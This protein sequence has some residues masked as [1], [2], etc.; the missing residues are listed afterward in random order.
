MVG[1]WFLVSNGYALALVTADETLGDESTIIEP[2]SE[3]ENVLTIRGGAKRGD[4]LFHS[5][6]TFS[7]TELQRVEFDV[8]EGVEQ[9][10]AR[11]TGENTSAIA[12]QVVGPNNV[13]VILI[14]PG[15]VDFIA[16]ASGSED[17][18]EQ[19]DMGGSILVSTADT[20]EF[21]LNSENR[22]RFSACDPEVPP[23]S[24]TI[25]PSALLFGQA[26][27]AEIT[28]QAAPGN[29]Q[30]KEGLTVQPGKSLVLL[31]G[32][33]TV[34]ARKLTAFG[35]RIEIGAVAE[36]GKVGLTRAAQDWILDVPLNIALGNVKLAAA[37]QATIEA[38]EFGG[39]TIKLTAAAV[40]LLDAAD[41]V[42]DTKGNSD[43]GDI[44]ILASDRVT[45]K[46]TGPESA[47]FGGGIA[48]NVL[49]GGTGAG[50]NI[51]IAAP[52]VELLDGAQLQT[53][54]Q[55]TG[56]AGSIIISADDQVTISGVGIDGFASGIFS[57][58]FECDATGAG[59]SIMISTAMLDAKKGAQL[60]AGNTCG[61]GSP[62]SIVIS[63]SKHVE[64]T[65]D[66]AVFSL[67]KGSRG[68]GGLIAIT[69]PQLTMTGGS[70]LVTSARGEGNGGDIMI[71]AEEQVTFDGTTE[72][73]SVEEQ[74]S[75]AF[76]TVDKGGVGGDITIATRELTVQQGAQLS[77]SSRG[78]GEAGQI[79]I[80]AST[81]AL[82]DG[83]SRNFSSGAYS[84]A[85]GGGR[86]EE[87]RML[88]KTPSCELQN[89]AI[90]VPDLPSCKDP[91]EPNS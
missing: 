72:E 12:G 2:A 32:D 39:G 10:I 15:G 26:Q 36:S 3:I 66:S 62:G 91:S 59:G 74:P 14:S 82:F 80:L 87:K 38:D 21:E 27:P 16:S 37:A 52:L 57:D 88:I 53:A 81:R 5:F 63:A 19:I 44:T 61:A 6:E 69:T 42:A 4:N 85:V 49:E 31:G 76:S 83:Q 89:E 30:N 55:G 73:G 8:E 34:T 1:F 40:E 71:I 90:L 58:V 41:L 65:E 22:E 23:E 18:L 45:L 51:T 35:G 47:A 78:N 64:F 50:G 68:K 20:L 54:T 24:L 28:V 48:S 25:Q 56:N 70:Q 11:V 7:P 86:G 67:S 60:S 43:A 33:V 29:P 17:R 9:V 75:G 77:S 84:R 79:T 46:Q 13:D